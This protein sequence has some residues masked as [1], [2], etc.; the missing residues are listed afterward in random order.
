M[1]DG[2]N[3]TTE[4]LVELERQLAGVPEIL[5]A[6]VRPVV[7]RGALN[8]KNDWRRRWSGLAHAPAV[9]RAISFDTRV[10]ADEIKA[11]V[12]PDKAAR[13]GALGNILEFGTVKNAPIPGGLPALAAEEPRF[14]E[15]LQAVVEEIIDG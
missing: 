12:G 8:I 3:I 15:A 7:Q 5:P 4:G 1:A 14:V 9:P 6:R 11:E 13:Q 10:G 2:L